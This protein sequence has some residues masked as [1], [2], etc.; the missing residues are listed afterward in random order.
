MINKQPGNIKSTINILLSQDFFPKIGGAHKWL[1]EVYKTWPDPV[2]VLTQDYSRHPE[3]ISQQIQFDSQNHGSIEITRRDL[4][5]DDINLFNSKYL[6]RFFKTLKLIQTIRAQKTLT[7][8]CLRAFPEGIVGLAL[9]LFCRQK[10]KFVTYAHGEEILIART[11]RQLQLFA[12]MV[13]KRSDLV[14]ANSNSTKKLVKDLA[15][16]AKIAVIHPGVDTNAFNVSVERCTE[17]RKKLGWPEDTVILITIARMEPRK[18][19]A[20]VIEVMAG[21]LKEGLPLGYLLGG[22]GEEDANLRKLVN[23]LGLDDRVKF[24]GRVPEKE[25]PLCFASSDIHVMPSVQVGSMIEGFGIVFLEAAAAGVPSIAGN[26]GGQSEAV[27]HGKT[28]LVVDGSNL[29]ELKQAIR[30]LAE[31]KPIREQMGSEGK[32]WAKK[33]DWDNVTQQSVVEIGRTLYS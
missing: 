3:L 19:H 14:I 11:S 9:R 26:V 30:Y 18:N 7:L 16:D 22:T 15:P 24:L 21:L 31:N 27:L 8:H 32:I 28:G 13:Y 29:S 20:A 5:I 1:Y 4:E 12:R 17:Y 33:C 10:C 6:V 2:I 25:K 23:K